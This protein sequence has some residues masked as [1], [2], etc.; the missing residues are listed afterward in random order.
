MIPL[1]MLRDVITVRKGT[2]TGAPDIYGN[3]TME[4]TSTPNVPALV[5]PSG[6][7]DELEIQRDTRIARYNI[8]VD[9]NTDINGISEIIWS[10]ITMK[11]EGEPFLFMARGLPHHYE[12]K[13]RGIRG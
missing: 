4:Y 8:I 11:V 12:I 2:E 3:P 1:G 13:A 7:P 9:P 5:W 6:I 10:G